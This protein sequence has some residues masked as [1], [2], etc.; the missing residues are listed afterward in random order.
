[1]RTT[2]I[3]DDKL[4]THARRLSKEKTLSAILNACLKDWVRQHSRTEIEA[5]LAKE[6]REANPE[7]G[8]ISRDFTAI[9]QEG[10]PKW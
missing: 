1:M 7:S 3:L 5:R 4:V 8:R 9:D 2:V 10:W 6:Y